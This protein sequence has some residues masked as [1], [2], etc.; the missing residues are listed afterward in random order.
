MSAT[1]T[2]PAWLL[3]VIAVYGEPR[4]GLFRDEPVRIRDDDGTYEKRFWVWFPSNRNHNICI[5]RYWGWANYAE[6]TTY[7]QWVVHIASHL[8]DMPEVEWTARTEPD[9]KLMRMLLD[10]TGFLTT[11]CRG[12][13]DD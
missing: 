5:K 1:T 2:R 7:D 4:P 10:A 8:A 12:K 9:D 11:P 6:R 13:D 3:D